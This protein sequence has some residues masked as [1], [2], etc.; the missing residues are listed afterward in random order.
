MRFKRALDYGF[1]IVV[2][3]LAL[4][5]GIRQ[6]PRIHAQSNPGAPI[7]YT[8]T[9]EKTLM[10]ADGNTTGGMTVTWAVRSDGSRAYALFLI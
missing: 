7:P 2:V 1:W 4:N 9:L 10:R 3:G 8:V 6:L 5:L